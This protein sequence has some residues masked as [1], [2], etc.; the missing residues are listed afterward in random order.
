MILAEFK[1]LLKRV[2]GANKVLV[3]IFYFFGYTLIYIISL[4]FVG[5]SAH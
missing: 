2:S 5:L 4:G 1:V 3:F